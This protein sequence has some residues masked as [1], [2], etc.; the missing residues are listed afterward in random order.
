[1]FNY[2]CAGKTQKIACADGLFSVL[3][4]K[5]YLWVLVIENEFLVE[6][7]E[8]KLPSYII[9]IITSFLEFG[10]GEKVRILRRQN[11]KVNIT[12]MANYYGNNYFEKK[13]F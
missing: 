6:L 7:G 13:S 3:C 5:D 1:M 9:I 11:S 4:Q 2:I 8:I 12:H 10:C